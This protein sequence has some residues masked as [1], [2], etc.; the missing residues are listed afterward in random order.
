MATVDFPYVSWSPLELASLTLANYAQTGFRLVSLISEAD[1][2][3]A[4]LRR[5]GMEPLMG[6]Q[7]ASL[8]GYASSLAEAGDASPFGTIMR[9]I[10]RGVP[11]AVHGLSRF[12]TKA[13][14]AAPYGGGQIAEDEGWAAPH[15]DFPPPPEEQEEAVGNIDADTLRFFAAIMATLALELPPGQPRDE[16]RDDEGWAAPP[17]RGPLV[18]D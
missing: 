10:V 6:A 5:S 12:L 2:F 7:A 16:L 4:Q 14:I 17:R 15:E 8:V 3:S 11:K 9:K 1:H 18:G 13:G